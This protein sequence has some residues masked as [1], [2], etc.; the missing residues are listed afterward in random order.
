MLPYM[1]LGGNGGLDDMFSGMLDMN[2][3]DDEEDE[4]EE[5][6]E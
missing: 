3:L 6:E 5:E 2:E 4:I 1:M